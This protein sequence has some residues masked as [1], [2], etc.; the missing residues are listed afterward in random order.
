MNKKAYFIIV[1]LVIIVFSSL[2]FFR[3][4]APLAP[5]I[6]GIVLETPKPLITFALEDMNGN[7][8]TDQS[9]LG[10][11]SL[12]FFG[13][14]TC[15]D[16]CPTTLSTLNQVVEKLHKEPG[17]PMPKIIFVSVD[18]QRDTPEKLKQYVEHFNKDF[19]A[20]TGNDT[21]LT[22][23]SRQLG[24]VYEKVYLDDSEYL[25]DHSGSIALINRRG[26]I[27]AYFTPPLDAK[28]IAK[29]YMSVVG[30]AS[31]CTATP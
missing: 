3:K 8:F 17:I 1:L 27:Q 11:W 6:H 22:E 20:I 28:T 24:V 13:F 19:L 23:F 5:Q 12:V 9:F 4:E 26:A 18:P 7:S 10:H 16:I 25:V 15:P 2:Y 29:D 21:Q 14:T 31:P 30:H